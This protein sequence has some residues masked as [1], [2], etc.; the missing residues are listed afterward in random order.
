V[1][2]SSSSNGKLIM[3]EGKTPEK[4]AATDLRYFSR[5]YT[6]YRLRTPSWQSWSSTICD[7]H[8][9]GMSYVCLSGA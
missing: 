7:Y 8:G 2:A 5:A 6:R 1:A 9:L 3:K 4:L